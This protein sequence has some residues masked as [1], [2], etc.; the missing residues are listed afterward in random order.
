MTNAPKRRPTTAVGSVWVVVL[1]H[2]VLPSPSPARTCGFRRAIVAHVAPTTPDTAVGVAD[3]RHYADR[4]CPRSNPSTSRTTDPDGEGRQPLQAAR[5]RVPV[6]RD[7]RRLP[8]DL[9]LRPGRRAAAAQ[10]EGRVVA[11]D[12]AAA[13]RRRRARR[14]DPVAARGLG[15]VGPPLELHRPA[16][17]LPELRRALPRRQARRSRHLPELRGRALAS[18]RP[19]SSTSCSRRTPA[20]SR[21]D[22]RGGLPA[23]RDGPGHVH[24][25]RQR[26]AAPAA[27]SRR[28]ASPRSASR[29]ATRSRP[30][31]SCSAPA[32]SS[33][34]RWSSSCRPT[35]RQQWY[36][37]WCDERCRLVRR[38][39]HPR[40]QAAPARPRRRRA[41]PLL[42]RHLRRRVPL[43]VGLGRARGHRQ[44]RRLRPHRST[45]STRARSSTTSTRPP[46]S[47]TCRTS[48]SRPPAPPAR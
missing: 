33:R 41:E 36:E 25:L 12:G 35:R 39:R 20:R 8:V 24:Q 47:A 3:R 7:L 34:W 5:L 14:R 45:P 38:A 28:S 46:T 18:P 44:P 42:E 43:P 4:P 10:R 16:G 30:A 37:Y 15:G 11:V 1:G 9:R 48:S 2:L 21:S 19:A 23:A 32:S 13:R 17:R 6:G 29:S 27:R 40:R 22:A 31:T 26:A